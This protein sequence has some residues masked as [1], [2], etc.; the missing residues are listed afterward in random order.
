MTPRYRRDS[1]RLLSRR[2]VI[3]LL[4]AAGALW[5]AGGV[6]PWRVLADEQVPSCI[7]RPEQTEGPYFVDER[8][9]RSDIRSD[10]AD[11]VV[12]PGTPLALTL[13]V[14]RLDGAGCRPLPGAHVDIWHC[15]AL[16]IYSDVR[17]PD[18]NT[19]GK[20]FFRGYQLTDAQ[21]Q[22]RFVTI[23]PGWYEGRTVHIHFKIRTDPTAR[24]SFEFTSQMYF[25][26]GLTDRVHA[27][28]PY[29]AR[30]P[31]TARNQHD[32]IFRRGGDQ[33][34]LA[35]TPAAAGYAATFPIGLKLP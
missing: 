20:K 3:S 25:D 13:H 6:R 31:R 4:G 12:G 9:H 14:S 5:L 19:I 32:R 1:G 23:Y 15:D 34:M 24:R 10:P 27:A 8:L 35:P 30:G 29:A 22:A 16:G 26:D 2:D 17:D 28:P 11:G 33:L 7:V 21:G 18:F